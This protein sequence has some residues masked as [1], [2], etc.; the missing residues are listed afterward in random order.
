MLRA[1]QMKDAANA[2]ARETLYAGTIANAVD[3]MEIPLSALKQSVLA[4]EKRI[5]DLVGRTKNP[6]LRRPLYAVSANIASGAQLPASPTGNGGE[7]VG[8]IAAVVD[9][10]DN[11]PLTEKTKQ[12]V[13]RRID[14]AGGFYKLAAYHYCIEDTR[15]FHTRDNVKV[16][17]CA[18]NFAAQSAQYDLAN[19][20]SPLPE[21][22]ETFWIADVLANLAQ[23]NWFGNEAQGYAALSAR[24]EQMLLQGVVPQVV[25]PDSTA[26]ENPIKN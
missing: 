6:M 4:S 5:A 21:Q 1:N 16:E 7:F 8:H 19:G 24:C 12:E 22:L 15:I 26:N 23:E 9:A 17:G 3:G 25:L 18:W 20:V 13:L 14:N 10:I 11:R 2:T